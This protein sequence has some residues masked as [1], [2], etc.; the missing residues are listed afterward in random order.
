MKIPRALVAVGA[1]VVLPVALLPAG[2]ASAGES[3]ATATETIMFDGFCDGMTIDV[4]STG[5]GTAGT[6][7]GTLAGC[8]TGPILGSA[9][10]KK[11]TYGVEVGREFISIP[12]YTLFSVI[13]NDHTFTHYA[14][15]GDVISELITGTW[16]LATPGAP[17][18]SNT[19]GVSSIGAA[20]ATQGTPAA[21]QLP[22]KGP[23]TL[24]ITFDGYCDGM[25]LVNPSQG[26]G[27]RRTV[28]GVLT[29][30]ADPMPLM[31]AKG[32]V[33]GV[34]T[35]YAVTYD[36]GGGT[37]LHTV[38]LRDGTWAHYATDGTQITLLNSGTWTEGAPPQEAGLTASTDIG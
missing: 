33:Q 31:G 3:S 23:E 9:A 37:Y 13:R 29:G 1:A 22:R 7:D 11:G 6:L 16:S 35:S 27:V 38:V 15:N 18:A 2:A 20:L 12:Q 26:T 28:D 30:C 21:V 10:P 5:L 34:N 24:E 17:Q 32:L 19:S 4:P 25:T 36:G 14:I 8:E